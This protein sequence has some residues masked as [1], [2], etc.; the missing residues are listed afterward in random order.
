MREKKN[1]RRSHLHTKDKNKGRKSNYFF[2]KPI[3]W[4]H[5]TDFKRQN[6][7]P[8]EQINVKNQ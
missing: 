6:H 2:E 1:Y 3:L 5:F 4:K 7:M 8:E